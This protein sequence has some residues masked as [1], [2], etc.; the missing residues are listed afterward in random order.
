MKNI[1]KICITLMMVLMMAVPTFATTADFVPSI[2]EKPEVDLD[3]SDKDDSDSQD[4]AIDG[5][6][7][8]A[9]GDDTNVVLWAGL[10]V[11]AVAGLVIVLKGRHSEEN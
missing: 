7:V 2:D 5:E 11:V 3:I 9:T 4:D 10:G 6:N 8:P 1:V